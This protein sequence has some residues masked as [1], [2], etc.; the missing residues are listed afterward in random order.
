MND[1]VESIGRPIGACFALAAFAIAIAAG[2]LAQNDA[3][4]VLGRAIFVLVVC[5]VLGG[6]LGLVL[7]AISSEAIEAHGIEM[8]GHGSRPI[9]AS[10][11]AGSATGGLHADAREVRRAA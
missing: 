11:S 7:S 4:T 10:L 8:G 2:L 1:D 3:V 5:R 9:E 6:M